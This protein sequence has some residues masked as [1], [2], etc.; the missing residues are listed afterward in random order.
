MEGAVHHSSLD[1]RDAMST[2]RAACLACRRHHRPPGVLP[3]RARRRVERAAPPSARGVLPRCPRRRP[4]PLL[5]PSLRCAGTQ[6]RSRHPSTVA[7]LALNTR[8]PAPGPD[9]LHLQHGQEHLRLRPRGGHRQRAPRE[10][11]QGGDQPDVLRRAD[12][13][14][15]GC[16]TTPPAPPAASAARPDSSAARR[17]R[18]VGGSDAA[19]GPVSALVAVA[20]APHSGQRMSACPSPR[21]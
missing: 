21:V 11:P 16:G 15:D 20:S 14:R 6:T 19:G 9:R 1:A 13:P 12:G 2:F 17:A 8:P 5:A 18:C 4:G 7:L 3:L 10:R